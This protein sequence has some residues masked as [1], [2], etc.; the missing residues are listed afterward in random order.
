MTPERAKELLPIIQAFAEGK[1]IQYR[2][3]PAYMWH[4]CPNGASFNGR[5]EYRIKPATLKY[6]L[7][8]V[9]LSDEMRVVAWNDQPGWGIAHIESGQNFIRW[10]DTEWQEVEV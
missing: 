1:V 4:P 2:E 9:R 10:I 3:T 6:R 7:Y 8:I 5:G